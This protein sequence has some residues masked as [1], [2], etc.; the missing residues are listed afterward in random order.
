MGITILIALGL[1]AL[2][3]WFIIDGDAYLGILMV[4]FAFLLSSMLSIL[5]FG[6]GYALP[7]ESYQFHTASEYEL[8]SLKDDGV[9]VTGSKGCGSTYTVSY[10]TEEGIQTKTVETNCCMLVYDEKPR[11]IVRDGG[12][13]DWW[14]YLYAFPNKT[15]CILYVP[16]GTVQ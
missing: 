4:I 16:K 9:Y 13:K 15:H 10:R 7:N 1:I 12:F 2:A 5:F 8:V 3:V 11:M 6:I 14:T